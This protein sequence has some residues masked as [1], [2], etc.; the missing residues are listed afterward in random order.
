MQKKISV[1]RLWVIYTMLCENKKKK[2]YREDKGEGWWVGVR[3]IAVE[4]HVPSKGI[5]E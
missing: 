5:S 1:R 2:K 3:G 4:A